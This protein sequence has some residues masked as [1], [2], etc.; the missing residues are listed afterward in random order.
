[1]EDFKHDDILVRTNCQHVFHRA[2]CREWL[3]QARTCPICRDDLVTSHLT[4]TNNIADTDGHENNDDGDIEISSL[5]PTRPPVSNSVD[6]S[7]QPATIPIGPTGRPV[8]GLI[9]L[10]QN[11]SHGGIENSTGIA[12]VTEQNETDAT[13]PAA[14]TTNSVIPPTTSHCPEVTESPAVENIIVS[15]PITDDAERGS[16]L[17]QT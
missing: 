14:D 2:C 8:V 6:Y 17:S 1:M 10:I 5:G 16:D 3:R 13:P 9:R 11:V 15:P 12:N 7:L 4:E